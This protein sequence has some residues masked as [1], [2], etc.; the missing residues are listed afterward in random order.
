M[1]VERGFS[2]VEIMVAMVIGLLS[3]LVIIQVFSM[4]EGQKRTTTGGDDAQN[5]GA[6]ALYE[7]QRDVRQSGYG[8]S[9]LRL[10]GCSVQL[11]AGI[12]LAEIAPV[13]I[14]PLK[15]DATAAIPPGDANTDTL[16]ISYGN[17]DGVA[18]GNIIT[19]Q[20]GAAIYAVQTPTQFHPQLATAQLQ[21]YVIAEPLNRPV[22]CALTLDRVVSVSNPNVT[23]TTGVAGMANGT[24]FNLGPSPKFKA[25]AVR[26]GNLTACDYMVNDCSDAGSALN[27]AIWVPIANNI[28]S[29][30]AEYGR[31]STATMDGVA[32]VYDQTIAV[33]PTVP[34][35]Q[36]GLVRVA[37][38][39]LVLV[40]RNTQPGPANTTTAAPNWLGTAGSPIN[41]TATIVPANMTW[42]NFR[43]KVFQTVVPLRNIT[44]MGAQAGC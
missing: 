8:T 15:S 19:A 18:E 22:N 14:N 5:T 25:Y 3:M 21:D 10:L 32:D 28:V 23:V 44:S 40:A 13:I 27:S 31:D 24:L 1:K 16:L 26:N 36:C 42:Q 35:T 29:M 37:A 38:V 6:I 39:R 30:R 33:P 7:L 9:A 17:S 2:L 11:R 43:Y 34:S 4:F 41:L 12:S 20:P